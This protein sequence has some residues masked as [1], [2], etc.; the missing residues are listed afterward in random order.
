VIYINF[1]EVLKYKFDRGMFLK[2]VPLGMFI[3]VAVISKRQVYFYSFLCWRDD[4]FISL[5]KKL[6]RKVLYF[7]VICTDMK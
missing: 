5:L 7:D 4:D 2:N 1:E 3:I 6:I